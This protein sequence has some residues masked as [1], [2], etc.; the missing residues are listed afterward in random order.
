M[1]KVEDGNAVSRGKRLFDCW[2]KVS[3]AEWQAD[4]LYGETRP[5]NIIVWDGKDTR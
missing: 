3:G 1:R 4:G 2:E 5:K